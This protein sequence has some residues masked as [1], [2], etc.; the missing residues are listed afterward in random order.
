[1]SV[2]QK[3]IDNT[4]VIS[5]ESLVPSKIVH[6]EYPLTQEARD[7]VLQSRE[8]ISN[9]LHGKD[10]RVVVVVGPCSV[11][12]VTAAIEYARKLKSI[13]KKYSKTLLIVMRVYF[14]KPR[15]TVGWKG[16][17]ND[18]NLDNSFQINKGLRLARKL[19]L[20]ISGIG[21]P[22]ATEFLDVIVPQYISDLISWGAI[23][24]RTTE[25]QIHR[26]LASGLSCPIGFKNGTNGD[27]GISVDA[28]KASMSKH[29]FLG[30]T[31]SGTTAIFETTGN[32][33]VHIILRGGKLSPNYNEKFVS[34]ADKFLKIG[35][36]PRKLM[37][38]CSHGN[39]Y[40]DYRKQIIV[41]KNVCKQIFNN[42]KN[43]LGLMIE[44]NLKEG[45]QSID[46]DVLE[47]GKSVTDACVGWEETERM[48]D[49]ISNAVRAII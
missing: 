19:L 16:L 25:S 20:D 46:S 3:K 38:D 40:K 37:I 1:M 35:N 30:V 32:H 11:H 21:L 41:V 17:I 6:D 34:E 45:S 23:G 29:H 10:K 36:L 26:E 7:T 8:D 27:I 28:V 13:S 39:S 33:D 9:I 31:E 18:P 43:V 42:S 24:A 2:L 47:Y 44:S 22:C 14:E 12:D 15:T 4:R 49:E 5:S 48:L